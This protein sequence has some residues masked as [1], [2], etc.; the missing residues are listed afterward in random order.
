MQARA[1]NEEGITA[2]TWIGSYHAPPATVTG[3]IRGDLC[4][5]DSTL[6]VGELAIADHRG[7]QLGPADVARIAAEARVGGMLSGKVT[8]RH[9][10]VP[11]MVGNINIFSHACSSHCQWKALLQHRYCTTT[12]LAQMTESSFICLSSLL[13]CCAVAVGYSIALDG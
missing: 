10:L 2:F 11:T 13:C 4:L 6:G 12:S 5:V 1:L 7:S 8:C 9:H 3:S